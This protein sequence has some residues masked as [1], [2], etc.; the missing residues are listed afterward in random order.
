MLTACNVWMYFRIKRHQFFFLFLLPARINVIL[1][2]LENREW[3]RKKSATYTDIHRYFHEKLQQYSYSRWI[4]IV[5]PLKYR[6]KSRHK[7]KRLWTEYFVIQTLTIGLWVVL[8]VDYVHWHYF[9]PPHAF[10]CC[11]ICYS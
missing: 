6:P 4:S 3:E 2:F 5:Q 1:L 7:G 8:S 9:F 11:F 10:H